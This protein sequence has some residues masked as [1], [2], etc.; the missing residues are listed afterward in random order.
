MNSETLFVKVTIL[1]K[2]LSFVILHL[3]DLASTST[4]T[5]MAEIASKLSNH[6]SEVKNVCFLVLIR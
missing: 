2:K 1:N 4:Y 6:K 3:S 5:T